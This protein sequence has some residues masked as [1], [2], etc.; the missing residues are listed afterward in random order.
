MK[1]KF[2]YK[3]YDTKFFNRLTPYY[4]STFPILIHP[5]AQQVIYTTD[6]DDYEIIM[7]DL[8]TNEE[9]KIGEHEDSFIA[10]SQSRDGNTLMNYTVDGVVKMWDVPT[11]ELMLRVK[12]DDYD[13]EWLDQYTD[14]GEFYNYPDFYLKISPDASYFICYIDKVEYGRFDI[15]DVESKDI[16][17]IIGLD[18]FMLEFKISPDSKC[19]A[20]LTDENSIRVLDSNLSV[21]EIKFELF[22]EEDRIYDFIFYNNQ[23]ILLIRNNN[24]IQEF[25]IQSG[26][27]IQNH[28]FNNFGENSFL[29]NVSNIFDESKVAL[30]FSD[31]RGSELMIYNLEEKASLKR[32]K[33]TFN[34]SKNWAVKQIF[35]SAEGDIILTYFDNDIIK[36]WVDI[37]KFDLNSR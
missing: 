12:R 7:F 18:C 14:Y 31:D 10:L 36:I 32:F 15:W 27:E 35:A 19:I 1:A 33:I 28:N 2:V 13:F 23:R 20:Y 3:L 11:K 17:R 4:M 29:Y 25:A 6:E 9:F 22:G 37:H 5:N 26:E 16:H 34:E 21:K 24:I 8:F 30:V